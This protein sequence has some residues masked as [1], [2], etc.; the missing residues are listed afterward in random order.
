MFV[1]FNRFLAS[2]NTSCSSPPAGIVLGYTPLNVTGFVEALTKVIVAVLKWL[3]SEEDQATT[4]TVVGEVDLLPAGFVSV[5]KL[6]G[7]VNTPLLSIVPQV[8][9]Q[10]SESG[11]AVWSKTLVLAVFG[12]TSAYF[13]VDELTFW[14]AALKDCVCAGVIPTG[15]AAVLGVIDTRMP[16]S[17]PSVPVPVFFLS[18][19]AVAV[20]VTVGMG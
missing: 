18:A 8:G 20:K 17:N 1:V 16:E 3:V 15:T 12:C 19:S 6:A 7:A 5:G 4:K 14:K 9:S 13:A 11:L 2:R 10:V